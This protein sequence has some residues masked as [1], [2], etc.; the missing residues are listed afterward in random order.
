M[1]IVTL[2]VVF[3]IIGLWYYSYGKTRDHDLY[4]SIGTIILAV[5]V[6]RLLMVE[7]RTMTL[8]TRIIV[9]LMIGGLMLVS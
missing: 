9:L 5:V 2:L 8:L 3:A 1:S 4:R 7:L 6:G